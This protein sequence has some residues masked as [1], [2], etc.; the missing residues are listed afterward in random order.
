MVRTSRVA[1]CLFLLTLLI[2]LLSMGLDARHVSQFDELFHNIDRQDLDPQQRIPIRALRNRIRDE[3]VQMP[4]NFSTQSHQFVSEFLLC[5]SG[6]LDDQQFHKA[7]GRPKSPQQ[8]L[9]YELR[10]L[11]AEI[12]RLQRLTRHLN[13]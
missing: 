2:S 5:A 6:I 8:Q 13:R 11:H 1:P 9:R 7:T 10:Q 4:T 3:Q 12:M